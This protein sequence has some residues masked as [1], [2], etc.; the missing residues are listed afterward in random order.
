[1]HSYICILQLN[2]KFLRIPKRNKKAF[3][4]DQHRETIGKQ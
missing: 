2:A 4:R 1:M 3:F